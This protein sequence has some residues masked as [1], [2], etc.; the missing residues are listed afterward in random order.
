MDASGK[1]FPHHGRQSCAQTVVYNRRNASSLLQRFRRILS[2][3]RT[4]GPRFYNNLYLCQRVISPQQRHR[5]PATTLYL[6]QALLVT[7]TGP[8]NTDTAKSGD[9]VQVGAK[10][11]SSSPWTQRSG[12]QVPATRA[13]KPCPVTPRRGQK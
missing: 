4:T 9:S 11:D 7:V 8:Q 1:P 13:S 3:R 5:I 2:S 12:L 10:V 6:F